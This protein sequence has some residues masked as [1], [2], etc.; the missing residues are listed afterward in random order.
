MNDDKFGEKVR[1]TVLWLFISVWLK[2]T[3][4]AFK[5]KCSINWNNFRVRFL[6]DTAWNYIAKVA[7][8][9]AQFLHTP[10]P[11]ISRR[12]GL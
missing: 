2:K 6:A 5:K 11:K 9:P 12:K 8:R 7:L 1:C 3:R 4:L 10:I